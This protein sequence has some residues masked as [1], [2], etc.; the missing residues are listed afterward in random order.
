[1]LDALEEVIPRVDLVEASVA[2]AFLAVLA[3]E[4]SAAAVPVVAGRKNDIR[5]IKAT[6]TG[7]A[8]IIVRC[9]GINEKKFIKK[10]DNKNNV[11]ICRVQNVQKSV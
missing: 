6:P 5:Y 3:A 4:A 8:F 9:D 11:Y 1:M 10:Y 2:E 7:V